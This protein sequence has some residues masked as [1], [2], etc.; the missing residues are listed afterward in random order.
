[1]QICSD[2]NNQFKIMQRLIMKMDDFFH[3]FEAGIADAIASFK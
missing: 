2:V 1:M 3:L